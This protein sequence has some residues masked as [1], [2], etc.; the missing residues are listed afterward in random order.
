MYA[1][2]VWP[3]RRKEF[4]PICTSICDRDNNGR[5]FVIGVRDGIAE[6][7]DV[8]RGEPMGDLIE[9]FGP[10]IQA[11]KLL[12]EAQMSCAQG[13]RSLQRNPIQ[14]DTKRLATSIV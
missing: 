14:S 12:S 2:V 1:E 3:V 7:D 5:T 8:R 6:W 10:L 11:T 9:V 13:H 4:V